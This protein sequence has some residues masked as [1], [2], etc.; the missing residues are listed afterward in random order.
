MSLSTHTLSFGAI[1]VGHIKKLSFT[2]TN[3]GKK[4]LDGDIDLSAL[5]PPLS[6]VSGGGGFILK[7]SQGRRVTIQAEPTAA[8]TF[9]GIVTI[10]SGSLK[11]PVQ[12][13]TIHGRAK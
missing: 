3:A 7:H 5:V 1:K 10:F 9:A 2:I 4:T 12:T 11:K 13:V 8:G 6:L